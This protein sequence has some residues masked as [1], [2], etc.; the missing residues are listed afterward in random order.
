M[1]EVKIQVGPQPSDLGNW[2]KTY[3]LG[4]GTQMKKQEW[5]GVTLRYQ[6]HFEVEVSNNELDGPAQRAR[7]KSWA[8]GIVVSLGNVCSVRK[9]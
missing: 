8:E 2:M 9:E 1:E 4:E 7:E 5:V 3:S 6:Q